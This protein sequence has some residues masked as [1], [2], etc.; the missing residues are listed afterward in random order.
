MVKPKVEQVFPQERKKHMWSIL[1]N[2]FLQLF[3]FKK[4]HTVWW[5][6]RRENYAIQSAH[7]FFYKE[8][9]REMC[10]SDGFFFFFCLLFLY[11]CAEA[12]PT[13]MRTAWEFSGH[14]WDV[15]GLSLSD[16]PMEMIC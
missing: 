2:S 7:V 12:G 16:W 4:V 1:D 6:C 9:L 5:G 3:H 10:L 11:V 14:I 8:S 15:Q 13:L